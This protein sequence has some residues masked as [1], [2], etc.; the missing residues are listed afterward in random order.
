[1][2]FATKAY[3]ISHLTLNRRI[4]H[5]TLSQFVNAVLNMWPM[6]DITK[7]TMYRWIDRIELNRIEYGIS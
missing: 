6:S 7:K 1:M 5:F 4:I 3:N 2:E